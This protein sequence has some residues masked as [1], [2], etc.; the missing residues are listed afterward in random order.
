MSK[1][2]KKKLKM[3][4]KKQKKAQKKALKELCKNRA[5]LNK[6]RK[7]FM[8]EGYSDKKVGKVVK[9]CIKAFLKNM[10]TEEEDDL[11]SFMHEQD[12]RRRAY[13]EANTNDMTSFE[14]NVTKLEKSDSTE[15]K[16]KRTL[17]D[18]FA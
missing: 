17:V 3:D 18:L 10:V 11:Y 15:Q 1:K 13:R 8:M 7:I 14:N 9:K 12:M 16:K 2:K 5:I 6:F 4:Q